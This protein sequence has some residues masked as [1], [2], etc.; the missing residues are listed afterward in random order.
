MSSIWAAPLPARTLGRVSGDE[1]GALLRSLRRASRVSQEVLAERAS[2]SVRTLRDIENG[3]VLAPRRS[4]I[5]LLA[6]ALDLGPDATDRLLAKAPARVREHTT[7]DRARPV[8]QLPLDVADFT[9]REQELAGL[10]ALIEGRLAGPVPVVALSGQPGVGKSALAVHLAHQLRPRFPGGQLFVDLR[11][12]QLDPRAPAEVL[13]A[14]LRQLGVPGHDLPEDLDDRVERYRSIL[15]ERPM[16]VVLDNAVDAAQ[17]RPL[18][19]GA[20]GSAAIVTGRAQLS[21]LEGAHL[22]HLDVLATEHAQQLLG[23]I[24]GSGRVAREPAAAARIAE[25]CGGLPLALRIAG[26]RLAARPAWALSELADRL[27]AEHARL[28]E[29]V[30]GDL[31]VRASVALSYLGLDADARRALRLLGLLDAKEVAPWMLAA[32]LDSD[33]ARARSTLERLADVNLV[34][35]VGTG[36]SG[37][38]YRLHDLLWLFA[39]ERLHAEEP[40]AAVRAALGRL[41]ATHLSAARAALTR[42]GLTADPSPQLSPAAQRHLDR[43]ADAFSM[44]GAKDWLVE[45][46]AAQRDLT[47]RALADDEHWRTGLALVLAM[48]EL[49]EVLAA[50]QEWD[51]DCSAALEAARRHGD[52]AGEV[53]VALALGALRGHQRRYGDALALLEAGVAELERLGRGPALADALLTLGRVHRRAGDAAAA[54]RVLRASLDEARRCGDEQR[55][56][57]ALLFLAK[58]LR[59][60]R[61]EEEPLALLRAALEIFQRTGNVGWTSYVHLAMGI[62]L[63]EA[64]A[65]WGAAVALRH[66][67]TWIRLLDVPLWEAHILLQSGMNAATAG[68]PAA[69]RA[70]LTRSSSTFRSLNDPAAAKAAAILASLPNG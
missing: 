40:P 33:H 17:V 42:L 14:F 9:G 3:R 34:E 43:P 4:T 8:A 5:A 32:L 59:G 48:T 15:A 37:P 45:H 70:A 20:P 10:R 52:G 54:Q 67:M 66:T 26:A 29:L 55:E 23:H 57:R 51:E 49:W 68:R 36:R 38:R 21:D 28:D 12:A 60:G 46:L 44:R 13:G 30:L 69:A 62:A 65:H 27:G 56:G 61:G 24:A 63:R 2:I 39:A 50:W 7:V 64:G 31:E 53:A 22:L 35:P 16:L 6:E 18:L 11:G 58:A 47:R 41:A 19:P 1:L 25:R